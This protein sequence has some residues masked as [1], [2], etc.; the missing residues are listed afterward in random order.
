MVTE[1]SSGPFLALEIGRTDPNESAYKSFRCL[2][3]PFNPVSNKMI[4]DCS[5]GFLNFF[6]LNEFIYTGYCS[7]DSP[8]HNPRS[9][10]CEHCEECSALHRFGTRLLT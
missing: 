7:G 10:R 4:D 6:R 5:H 2:C 3:G 1:L 9:I 8:K